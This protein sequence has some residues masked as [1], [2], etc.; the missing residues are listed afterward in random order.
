MMTTP[1]LTPATI[2]HAE[3]LA[4]LFAAGGDATEG[5]SPEAM[6][7]ALGTLGVFGFIATRDEAATGFILM[8][9]LAGID[10]AEVLQLAVLPAARRS[11][12]AR[13]LLGA[14]LEK[15]HA[16]GAAQCFLE[17][18]EDNAPA[19]ALYAGAGFVEVGVRDAY[20]ARPESKVAAKIMALKLE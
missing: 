13:Y 19:L 18:A 8:R 9:A 17:V 10:E 15:S 4:Q 3:V 6:A 11:G 2:A 20:Y 1:T 12:V 5:W 7:A 16:M 14:A